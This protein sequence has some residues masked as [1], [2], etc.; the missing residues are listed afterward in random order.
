MIGFSLFY[1]LVSIIK[2]SHKSNIYFSNTRN[3]YRNWGSTEEFEK[4]F[5][6]SCKKVLFF[7]MVPSVGLFS[8]HLFGSIFLL[9]NVHSYTVGNMVLSYTII[10]A[11]IILYGQWSS[12][13]VTAFL[14]IIIGCIHFYTKQASESCIN[15]AA[16]LWNPASES[17]KLPKTTYTVKKAIKTYCK[18]LLI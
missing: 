17:I 8:D 18:T 15:D 16:K 9:Y 1:S 11:G 14:V 2:H 7:K 4:C 5:F 6:V 3:N 10:S 12:F 13:L